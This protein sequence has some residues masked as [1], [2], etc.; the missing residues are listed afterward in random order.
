MRPF[1]AISWVAKNLFKDIDVGRASTP[2]LIDIDADGDLDLVVGN[3]NGKLTYFE[4]TGT[5]SDPEFTRQT[6]SHNPF[7]GIDVGRASAPILIDID[8]DG[9]LD[10]VV[11]KRNGKLKYFENTGND[12]DPEFTR[13]MGLRNPFKGIKV[14]RGSTPNLI[15][16][17]GDG[18]LDLVVGKR[19]GKLEYFENTGND[20]D[21]EFTKRTGRHNPF[22]GIKVGRASAP[23]L[24]DID[25]DGDLDL[26]VGK[27]NGKLKFFENTGNNADK[28]FTSQSDDNNASKSVICFLKGTR[29]ATPT[30]EHRIET[31]LPGDM[32]S[33]TTGPSRVRFISR[34]THFLET[35]ESMDELPIRIA[36]GAFGHL[37]PVRDLYVSP[38]HAI[39][40]DGS[41]IHASALVNG[42]TITR[43]T[44]GDWT[45]QNR[46]IEY[47]NIELE[48]HQLITAEGLVVESLID[49]L[50]RSDWDN[51]TSY[52]T[53]YGEDLPIKELAFPRI[54]FAR[55]LSSA[56]RRRLWE[57]E[58]TALMCPHV[59]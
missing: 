34:T 7:K 55:Q 29:I 57:F 9:D 24:I 31:L 18:D 46:P 6:G 3:Q 53:L 28:K 41:L 56:L 13:R 26:V 21:P 44:I 47:L 51:Y 59:A 54:L 14:G 43:T 40:I 45:G 10:L 50:P 36:A 37:G 17:D 8:G 4:N 11:G 22:K 33:T 48:E 52:L 2:S 20:S 25:G 16:I 35:L 30:G 39:Y 49:N 5:E 23:S 58:K 12:S 42:A 32:V 19:N 1:N 38:A 27:W 15:D